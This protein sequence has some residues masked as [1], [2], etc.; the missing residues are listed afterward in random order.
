VFICLSSTIT[1]ESTSHRVFKQQIIFPTTTKSLSREVSHIPFPPFIYL[2]RFSYHLWMT[3]TKIPPAKANPLANGTALQKSFHSSIVT[4]DGNFPFY[5][6]KH[7]HASSTYH[8]L[9]TLA[10]ASSTCGIGTPRSAHFFIWFCFLRYLWLI[11][12]RRRWPIKVASSSQRSPTCRSSTI[13][14]LTLYVGCSRSFFEFI[15]GYWQL[16][17]GDFKERGY[18]EAV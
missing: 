3:A 1:Y 10:L 2:V 7:Q 14:Y 12:L 17:A 11:N 9:T 15:S 5:F 16:A 4:V 18:W 13:I 6:L 8:T